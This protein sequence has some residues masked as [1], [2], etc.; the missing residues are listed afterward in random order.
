MSV[1][2]WILMWIR[3]LICSFAL[4]FHFVFWT[5]KSCVLGNWKGHILGHT[6]TCFPFSQIWWLLKVVEKPSFVS[7]QKTRH[8][9]NIVISSNQCRLQQIL[10]L[11]LISAGSRLVAWFLAALAAGRVQH[12]RCCRPFV[13]WFVQLQWPQTLVQMSLICSNS[14]TPQQDKLQI[15]VLEH[16]MI[17]KIWGTLNFQGMIVV[18]DKLKWFPPNQHHFWGWRWQSFENDPRHAEIVRNVRMPS[19]LH[20]GH[21]CLRS[22][23]PESWSWPSPGSAAGWGIRRW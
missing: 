11:F 8:F 16:F 15:L 20:R 9:H 10:A 21:L 12:S 3:V 22:W 1:Y 2:T 5:R 18:F 17:L 4:E 6:H 19:A 23:N 13:P 14:K 7:F